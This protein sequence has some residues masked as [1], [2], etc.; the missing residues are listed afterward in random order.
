MSWFEVFQIRVL[1]NFFSGD[2]PEKIQGEV[3]V[4]LGTIFQSCPNI[5]KRHIFF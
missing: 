4:W 3:E 1:V 2:Y 5:Y